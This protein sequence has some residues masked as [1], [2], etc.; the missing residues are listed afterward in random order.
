MYKL[1][2]YRRISSFAGYS[3][4]PIRKKEKHLASYLVY[5]F[6]GV[7]GVAQAKEGDRDIRIQSA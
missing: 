5:S 7:Q 6:E 3:S 1:Y 4:H 2:L